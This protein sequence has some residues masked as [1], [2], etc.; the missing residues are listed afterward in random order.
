M[1]ENLPVF[2]SLLRTFLHFVP[3]RFNLGFGLAF[4]MF[5]YA[6]YRRSEWPQ[7]SCP[8]DHVWLFV[9]QFTLAK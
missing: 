1:H 4:R 8:H 7:F 5:V 6:F 2:H 3:K 9:F